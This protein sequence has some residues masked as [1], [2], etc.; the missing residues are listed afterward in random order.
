MNGV[1]VKLP[2]PVTLECNSQFPRRTM[3]S[4]LFRIRARAI[5]APRNVLKVEQ[6][7]YY[8]RFSFAK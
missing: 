3:H 8:F 4:S 2:R 5:S 6:G 7:E 1:A